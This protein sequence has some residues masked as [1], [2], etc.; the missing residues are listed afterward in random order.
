MTLIL[1][2]FVALTGVVFGSFINAWVWRTHAGLSVAKGRSRC[3]SCKHQLAWYDLLPVLSY[4]LL[5]GRCR[6]CKKPISAQ[7]PLVEA[8]TALLFGLLYWFLSP[9]GV[10]GWLQFVILLAVSVLFVAA[11]V[12]DALYMQLPEKFMLPAV[13]LGVI[14]LGLKAMQYG[15]GS[16]TTQLIGL[17]VVV[18]F[19]TA[20]WYFSRGRWLGAGDIRIAAVM[21]LFL[22]PKQLVVGLFCTY[23]VGSA[24]G[25]WV[26]SKSKKKRGI[27]VPFGPFMIIGFYLGLLFGN[28]LANW[29]LGLLR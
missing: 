25:V 2:V 26:L 9:A 23:L 28:T 27:K 17:A 12:Y 4:V 11:L 10:Y 19:Y 1:I 8:A 29:Y 24:Y 22:E 18:L 21:G 6:Y 20:Q 3:P 5:R 15:W 7:Y 16:V 13:A 14:S